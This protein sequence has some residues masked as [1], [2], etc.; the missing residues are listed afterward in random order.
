MPAD[1]HP[2]VVLPQL[3]LDELLGELQAR[4]AG[5]IGVR[6]RTHALLEAVLAVGS[7][8]ELDRCCGTSSRRR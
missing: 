1:P 4:V 7:D 8:L 3:R 2:A 5:V 6:D